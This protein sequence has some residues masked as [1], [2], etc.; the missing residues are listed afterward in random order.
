[1]NRA[2]AIF[3]GGCLG[4]IITLAVG[5]TLDCWPAPKSTTVDQRAQRQAEIY[6]NQQALDR[7]T[8]PD[9]S[10]RN[11]C[12]DGDGCAPLNSAI[13]SFVMYDGTVCI[14][15]TQ[16]GKPGILCESTS[17]ILREAGKR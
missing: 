2:A 8:A 15:D 6:R 7:A 12:A 14:R 4:A 17:D 13:E 16:G 5:L 9:G 11:F 10:S 1:M 3:I